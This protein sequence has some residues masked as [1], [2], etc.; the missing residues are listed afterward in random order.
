MKTVYN[1]GKKT[2]DNVT[3]IHTHIHI[4]TVNF[5]S[6]IHSNKI[7]VRDFGPLIP[8]L[9]FD[10]C[11]GALVLH[12]QGTLSLEYHYDHLLQKKSHKVHDH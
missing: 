7:S 1:V 4:Y 12:S 3:H 6:R 2:K 11:P 8:V 9:T 10:F 5:S